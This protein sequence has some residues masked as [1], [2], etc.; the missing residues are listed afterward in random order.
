ML[1]FPSLEAAQHAFERYASADRRLLPLWDLCRQAAPPTHEP[2]DGDPFEIDPLAA[3]K[4][5]DGWCAE[6]FFHEH[7]KSK[8][9]LLVGERRQ[10]PPHELH[11][12]QAFE[13]VYDLLLNWALH[14]PCSCCAP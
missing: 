10:D 8:L 14:R 6:L 1:S 12:P 3:D 7:V 13:E 4:P 5:D 2:D 11:T 9:M